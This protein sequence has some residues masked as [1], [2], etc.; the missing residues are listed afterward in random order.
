MLYLIPFLHQ[1]TTQ[2]YDKRE[3][4][5]CILFHF[6]IKPQ[7]L[8]M[9][10]FLLLVVSYSISTSNH[11]YKGRNTPVLPVVSY[12]IS[13]SNHNLFRH[14]HCRFRLY[15]IPFLH[16]TTTVMI[17]LP[18]LISCILFHFYIK[19]Q[20]FLVLFSS[21]ECCIL[22]HFY[23]K[24]QPDAT[25]ILGQMCCILFHFYIKPQLYNEYLCAIN[26]CILFHFYIKPQLSITTTKIPNVVSYSISTSNHN[27]LMASLKS[28]T[29]YLIPFL[30]QTTTYSA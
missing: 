8:S 4:D 16:Q 5:G 10:L 29:L 12:S 20:R 7:L 13:T 28:T 19:P 23:I 2:H 30:H 27:W 15:L 3:Q 22:F 26:S 18:R 6:Y 14:R 9:V 11:N 24:P 17:W 21:L 1:T 25:S